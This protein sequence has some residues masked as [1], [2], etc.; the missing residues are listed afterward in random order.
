MSFAL[1]FKVG[2]PKW[3]TEI[4]MSEKLNTTNDSTPQPKKGPVDRFPF[5]NSETQP[6]FLKRTSVIPFSKMP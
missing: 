3:K 5:S 1:F 6:D 4:A 2:Y